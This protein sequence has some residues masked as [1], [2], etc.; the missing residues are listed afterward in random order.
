M[1][2]V[3]LVPCLVSA[4]LVIFLAAEKLVWCLAD[5]YPP[6]MAMTRYV[7]DP[8]LLTPSAMQDI[9]HTSLTLP[10]LKYKR[11]ELFLRCGTPGLEG[12][13]HIR[14]YHGVGAEN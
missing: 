4:A 7:D 12:V 5:Y 14:P 1:N 6:A 13:W 3:V 8:A 11:G 10:E 9:C 2:K